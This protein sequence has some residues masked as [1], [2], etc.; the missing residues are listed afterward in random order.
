MHEPCMRHLR[1]DVAISQMQAI[2]IHIFC[3]ILSELGYA[4][5]KPR[6]QVTAVMYNSSMIDIFLMDVWIIAKS[7]EMPR[8]IES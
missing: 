8:F 6:F 2:I 3:P 5:F 4:H 1:C 7:Q